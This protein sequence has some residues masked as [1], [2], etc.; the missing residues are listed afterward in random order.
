MQTMDCRSRPIERVEQPWRINRDETGAAPHTSPKRDLQDTERSII[1]MPSSI[2]SPHSD[3]DNGV[4]QPGT[5]SFQ[6]RSEDGLFVQISPA[7]KGPP[8]T[9]AFRKGTVIG[10]RLDRAFSY[11]MLGRRIADLLRI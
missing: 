10:Q 6:R 5:S 9:A 11:P 4:L 8:L 7:V 3:E 2:W 1:F